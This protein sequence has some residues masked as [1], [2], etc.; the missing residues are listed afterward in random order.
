MIVESTAIP[1]PGR[2]EMRRASRREAILDVAQRSFLESGYAA[3]TMNAI[4]AEL[5]GSKG[6]LWSYFPSKELLFAAVLDRA[7][8]SFRTQVAVVLNPADPPERAIRGFC[9]RFV[10]RICRPESIALYRLVIGESQRFPEVGRIFYERAPAITRKIVADYLAGA[11]ERGQLKI[12]DAMLAA[13][14]LTHMCLAGMHQRFI[15]GLLDKPSAAMIKAE[16]DRAADL[17]LRAYG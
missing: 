4:A 17:F 7:T 3:T 9:R 8:A 6:T 1:P 13:E 15:L 12:E 5:G 2:R 16:A 11:A 10:E 14:Q